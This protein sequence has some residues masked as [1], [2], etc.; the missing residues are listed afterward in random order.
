MIMG[1][2]PED[3]IGPLP[4]YGKS[5]TCTLRI[6]LYYDPNFKSAEI[7]FFGINRYEG[8]KGLLTP[9]FGRSCG[10]IGHGWM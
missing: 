10:V 9:E 4:L 3:L 8:R 6:I 5:K 7:S 1:I 2:D